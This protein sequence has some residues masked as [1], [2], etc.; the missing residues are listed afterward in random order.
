MSE[1]QPDTG[2]A[3]RRYALPVALLVI[4]LPLGVGIVM[5]MGKP[6]PDDVLFRPI[7]G[8]PAQRERVAQSRWEPVATLTG[9]GAGNASFQIAGGADQWKATWDCDAGRFR[10]T[11]AQRSAAA[12]RTL[13]DAT[14]P[15]DG[16]RTRT[17]TGAHTLHVD[18]TGPWRVVVEQ[19]VHTALQEPALAGMTPAALISRGR[20][21]DVQRRAEGSVSL[22]RLRSGRLALR[23]E[24]FYTTGSPGLEVWLSQA[25]RPR[26]TLATRNAPHDNAG[27]LR[28]TLGTYNQLLP[29]EVSVDDIRS[30]VIWCP[31][32]TIAFGA[33]SMRPV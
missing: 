32:V 23:F 1:S 5:A 28:S 20:M 18:T 11:A 7:S 30:I 21:Y 8:G 2:S 14:C 29:P 17:S 31:T 12:R 6:P 33:A 10:M 26:S 22:F 15:G 13:A 16:S 3:V 25:R 9:A 4:G 24:N 27:R 19:Q